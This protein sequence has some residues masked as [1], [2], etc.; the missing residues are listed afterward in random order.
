MNALARTTTTMMHMNVR[1]IGRTSAARTFAHEAV[2]GGTVM[3]HPII[4]RSLQRTRHHEATGIR[5]HAIRMETVLTSPP[6]TPIRSMAMAKYH[7]EAVG[8]TAIKG[9]PAIKQA[10]LPREPNATF[11]CRH[12]A[13]GRTARLK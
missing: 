6:E 9:L 7:H 13:T 8:R 2:G 4:G 11:T 12:E 3:R 5:T 1:G 10:V